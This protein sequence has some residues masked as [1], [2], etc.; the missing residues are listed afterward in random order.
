MSKRTIDRLL[1]VYNAN[2]GKWNAILDGAKKLLAVDGCP[3]C[4]LT[5]GVFGEKAEWRACKESF[6]VPVEYVVPKEG[7]P[8]WVD[9][10]VIPKS[11]ENRDAAEAFL[12]TMLDPEN[13]RNFC[14]KGITYAPS[15]VKTHLTKEEQIF[16]GATP[17]IFA[18]AKFPNAAYQAANIDN[19][20]TIVNRLKA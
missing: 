15:N 20:N 14:T 8:S 1:F 4:S 10:M 11:C 9:V 17:E 7:A 5:H 13:Q 12:N 18:G 19:W 16:L 6:G 3:L 2:S